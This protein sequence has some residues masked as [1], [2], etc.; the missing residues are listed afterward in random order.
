MS[1]FTGS[2]RPASTPFASPSKVASKRSRTKYDYGDEDDLYSSA[3]D[4]WSAGDADSLSWDSE[5][6]DIRNFMPSPSAD[7]MSISSDDGDDRGCRGFPRKKLIVSE[8][9]QPYTF[10]KYNIRK[11]KFGQV[12]SNTAHTTP[13]ESTKCGCDDA[14]AV[15][16]PCINCVCTTL[17]YSC[18][19]ETCGCQGA[20]ACQ[21]PF[22]KIDVPSIFGPEPV[23]LHQCFI[24]WM[25]K[26]KDLRPEQINQELLFNLAVRNAHR[27]KDITDYYEP[28][29]EW[30]TKW[31]ALSEHE[32]DHNVGLQ[33]QMNRMAFTK[34]YVSMNVF[35]SLCRQ[36]GQWEGE[37]DVWHCK[38]GGE[39]MEWRNY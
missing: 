38:I 7:F 28:Y 31:N 3:E 11:L 13:T 10:M 20:A 35:F 4:Q 36:P 27:I 24:T 2:K 8:V 29:V 9:S 22:N 18:K 39:C 19:P 17:G 33:Q 37:D 15:E 16:Q 23:V 34:D 32:Q 25:Q 1:D 26:Q 14:D 5:V 12:T 21:N 30:R 6:D